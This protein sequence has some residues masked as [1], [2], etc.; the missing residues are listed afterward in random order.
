MWW[1]KSHIDAN[2]PWDNRIVEIKK[3]IKSGGSNS[4]EASK[5]PNSFHNWK[6]LAL[7]HNL[8]SNG[9]LCFTT[10]VKDYFQKVYSRHNTKSFYSGYTNF[11]V[12]NV[13]Y[14][15]TELHS[16]ADHMNLEINKD[17]VAEYAERNL[18]LIESELGLRFDS[19]D[20]NNDEVF[21]DKLTCYLKDKIQERPIYDNNYRKC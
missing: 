18:N 21:F 5:L 17:S 2:D 20:Y 3:M 4:A 13:I 1:I 16:L 7:K 11:S 19:I 9:K 12:D 14:T 8:L 15:G 10:Y 6:F